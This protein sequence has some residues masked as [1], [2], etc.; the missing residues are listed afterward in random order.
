V[1]LSLPSLS[2]HQAPRAT[3]RSLHQAAAS[4]SPQ[5]VAPSVY[6]SGA[7]TYPRCPSSAAQPA[8]AV[9][10]VA[11]PRS[12]HRVELPITLLCVVPPLVEL[13]IVLLSTAPPVELLRAVCVSPTVFWAISKPAQ[14]YTIPVSARRSIQLK[15]IGPDTYPWRIPHVSVSDP[16]GI[17]DTL[18]QGRIRTR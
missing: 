11:R 1:T 6:Y 8:V 5:L 16:H 15:I 2:Q 18:V 3:A 17:R 12:L 14:A 13:P 7:T 9:P 10:P 4:L